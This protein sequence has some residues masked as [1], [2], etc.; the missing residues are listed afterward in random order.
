M[1][2]TGRNAGRIARR[3]WAALV[4]SLAVGL[5]TGPTARGDDGPSPTARGANPPAPASASSVPRADAGDDQIGLVGRR[6]T[7]NAGGSTPRGATFR[8]FL[9]AGPTIDEP[10]QEGCYYAFTPTAAGTYRFGLVVAACRGDVAVVSDIDEVVVTV[11]E[12][13][14]PLLGAG[15]P[16]QTVAAIDQMLRGP[17]AAAGRATLEQ[18]AGAF[19]S[20][21]ARVPLY[22][23]FSDLSTELMRRLDVVIPADPSWRRYWSE[24]IFAP[25]SEH[26]AS[27]MQRA[28]L[29]LR[30]PQGQDQPLGQAHREQLQRLLAAYALEFRGRARVR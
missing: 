9:L 27:E 21:S 20:V 4:L 30:G 15:A 10:S 17:G 14:S 24:A 5:A 22:T 26:V 28:G 3:A 8:W 1:T 6:I 13:P 12:A 23:S 7:L 16:S 29:D 18:A 25:L 11:G 2:L 19:D